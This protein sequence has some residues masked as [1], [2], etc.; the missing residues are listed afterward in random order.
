MDLIRENATK[1]SREMLASIAVAQQSAEATREQT[2]L[3]RAEF[4]ATHR[5][6]IIVREVYLDG[7]QIWF[8]LVNADSGASRPPI[9]G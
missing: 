8:R 7:G 1:Q 3:S 6:R 9:P 2:E 5:P 4:T